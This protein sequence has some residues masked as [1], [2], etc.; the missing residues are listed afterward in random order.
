LLNAFK[1]ISRISEVLGIPKTIQVF[2]SI[3]PYDLSTKILNMN[4]DR[5]NELYKQIDDQKSMRGRTTEGII[6]AS[7]YIACRLEQ[8]PRTFKGKERGNN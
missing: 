5:A 2:P 7:L 1:E 3:S 6:A 8:V 4:K